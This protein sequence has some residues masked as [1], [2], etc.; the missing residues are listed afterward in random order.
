VL[1]IQVNAIF[2]HLLARLCREHNSRLVHLST[3]CVFSG[4][5]GNYS[6]KDRPD[7]E[8]I[9]GL[10]KLL[11]ETDGPGVVTLRTSMVGLE[12][13]RK[14][15]LV[16]WFL[17]HKGKSIKGWTKAI[18]SG[19]TTAELARVIERL[20]ETMPDARGLYHLSA[21]PISK[22]DLLTGLG[23][24][25]GGGTAIAPDDSFNCDRSLDSQRFRTVF[26]Y[27]PPA[28]DV[29]LDEL[30]AEILKGSA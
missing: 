1:S 15:G 29:M 28:W 21:A 14:T 8:D 27:T 19:L 5:K 22:F 18:F 26:G 6:E 10:S 11:G 7:P 16:E 9:Y 4:K 12:L 17:A 20:T 25:I 3:D 24:R 30:A 23:R 2:P 13:Q